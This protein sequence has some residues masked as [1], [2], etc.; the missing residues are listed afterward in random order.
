M[1]EVNSDDVR[2]LLSVENVSMFRGN[3]KRRWFRYDVPDVK[4]LDDVSFK[5]ERHR[6]L[7]VVG[8]Q[9][10]GK[11]PLTMGILKLAKVASGRIVFDSIDI[12][13][14]PVRKFRPVRKWIQVVF[15]DRFGQFREGCNIDNALR[16]AVQTWWP[17]AGKEEIHTRIERVMVSVGLREAVRYLFPVEMDPV[18]RQLAALAR[19]LIAE[20]EMLICHD[21]THGMD[22][23]EQA[24]VLNKISDLQ[25]AKRLTTLIVTDDLTV[26]HHMSD[27]IAILHR[28][29]I[30]ETGVT[31]SVIR[32]PEH[33]YTKRLV[34]CAV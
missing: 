19:S 22:A 14:L 32:R 4:L 13:A 29:K 33:D 20:P 7:A 6:S 15:P 12:T 3:S 28:G 8:E 5:V 16:E 34:S 11:F 17:R 18:E 31:K 23:V 10:S 1:D 26:A 24:E 27:D 21:I 25:E 2:A 30:L 9:S